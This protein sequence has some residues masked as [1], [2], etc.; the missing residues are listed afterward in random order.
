MEREEVISA[1]LVV[2]CVR[3]GL[4]QLHV[5]YFL[6]HIEIDTRHNPGIL[7]SREVRCKLSM[8]AYLI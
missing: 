7:S 3:N 1:T 2:F 4:I 8:I 6:L 5:T